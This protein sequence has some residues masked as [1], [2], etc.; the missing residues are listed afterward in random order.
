MGQRKRNGKGHGIDR[1]GPACLVGR[2]A[3]RSCQVG[4]GHVESGA[5][6]LL[7]P[8]RQRKGKE[9]ALQFT[10]N[11]AGILICTLAAILF[12]DSHVYAS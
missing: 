10:G 8:G 7:H 4:Q 2:A 6:P 12:S 3:E 11:D 1:N 5:C 9:S